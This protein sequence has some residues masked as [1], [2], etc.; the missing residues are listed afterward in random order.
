MTVGIV[1]L[2]ALGASTNVTMMDG[3]AQILTATAQK[4]LVAA[5]ISLHLRVAIQL[6]YIQS[7]RDN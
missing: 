5:A 1:L 6:Q 2:S 7:S 3:I 4:Q